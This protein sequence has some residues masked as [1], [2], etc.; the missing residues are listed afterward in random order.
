MSGP[1]PYLYSPRIT[2]SEPC[3]SIFADVLWVVGV[4]GEFLVLSLVV[5]DVLGGVLGWIGCVGGVVWSLVLLGYVEFG[6]FWGWFGRDFGLVR[7]WQTGVLYGRPSVRPENGIQKPV[8][9]WAISALPDSKSWTERGWYN[10]EGWWPGFGGVWQV[11]MA[12]L[13]GGLKHT[14]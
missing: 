1:L 3:Q 5:L 8:Q 13:V 11:H 6:R 4:F 12:R 14:G 2:R 9:I 7:A 10:I